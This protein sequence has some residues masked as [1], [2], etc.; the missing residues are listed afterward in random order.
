MEEMLVDACAMKIVKNPS[1]F[2]VIVTS[3]MFGDILSDEASVLVGGLGIAYSG[4]I[5]EKTAVFEPVHGSAPKY[6]GRNIAN[7]IAAIMASKMMLEFL[8]EKDSAAIVENAVIRA[9]REN[10]VTHDLG[11]N[12]TM[13][14]VTR[15]IVKLVE[16]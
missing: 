15:A 14:E 10:K 5:G 1:Q 9:I 16:K 6:V 11:G 2:Q 7:P 13:E 4:N 3:N 12:L 8:G